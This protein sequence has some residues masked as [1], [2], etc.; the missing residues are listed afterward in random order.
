MKDGKINEECDSP[1]LLAERKTL[2]DY[3][4]G[5]AQQKKEN[6]WNVD[7]QIYMRTPIFGQEQHSDPSNELVYL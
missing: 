6:I 1:E 4:E 2:Q 3:K 7:A 5:Q